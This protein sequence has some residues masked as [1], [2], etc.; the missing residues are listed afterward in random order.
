[1]RNGSLWSEVFE[2]EVISH[3][4]IQRLQAWSLL[5]VIWKHTILCNRSVFYFHNSLATPMTNWVQIFTDFLFYEFVGIHQV[6][7]LVFD[8]YQMCP[9]PLTV[10][11]G[12]WCN[13]HIDQRSRALWTIIGLL[14]VQVK[15]PWGAIGIRRTAKWD[16]KTNLST[17]TVSCVDRKVYWRV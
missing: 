8:N 4:N 16:T 14:W 10:T 1:M 5:L 2:K 6:R 7:I 12:M 15:V 13:L 3:S 11:S 17:P 9:V